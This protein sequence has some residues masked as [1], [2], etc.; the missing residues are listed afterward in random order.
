LTDMKVSPAK[1]EIEKLVLLIEEH[2]HRY[3]VLN[4]PVISDEEYDRLL[5]KLIDLEEE[6][7]KFKSA[8]SPTQRV[9]AKVQGDLPT[10][11]HRLPMLSLDNTYSLE[12]LKQ[13]YERVVK[14]LD[15]LQPALTAE[16]KIDGLSCALTY[17]HGQL[18]LA[19]TRGDGSTGEDVTHNA[20]TIRDIP[21]SLKGKVPNLLEVRGEVYMDKKD[22]N[23][24]NGQRKDNGEVLFANPRN[25]AAGSLKLLDARLTAQRRLKFFVH[26]PGLWE[27]KAPL[28]QWEFLEQV[29]RNGFVVNSYNRLCRNFDEVIVFCKE[30]A[31]KRE[32][33]SFDVDGIVVKVNDL[34]QQA[35]LGHTLKSPRWAVAFKFPAYQASTVIKE[36][37][38]QVGR[39]GVLTPVA[40]LEPVPCAGVVISRA[41]LHNFDEIK[42]LGVNSGDRVLLERAGD[43]I[44]KIVKVLEKNS[45]GEFVI[46]K[47]CP[48]CNAKIQ[49][50]KEGDV[51][52]RC[53]NPSCPKQLERLLVHFASRGAMD[54]EGLGES[55]VDQLLGHGLISDLADIY[56]LKKEQ[57]LALDL[58]ADKKAENLLKAITVSKSKPLSKFLY[59]LGIANIGIKAAVNL[60]GHCGSLDAIINIQAEQL[61]TIDEIGPVMAGSVVEY[62]KQP[63]VKKLLAKFKDGGLNFLEP[64]RQ[65]SGN[66][67]EGKKFV[68][69]GE[70]SGINREEAG[71]WVQ[72]Q[73]G[74]VLAS[75][76]KNLDYLVVGENPGSKLAQAKQLGVKILNQK[77][78]EAIFLK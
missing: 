43:V 3:Y 76:S 18:V 56:F 63:Q 14:G 54:I 8:A 34:K 15:G 23:K 75:V 44:P 12:E 41:T 7:P 2:N 9:G 62:F 48:S 33:I 60:A 32:E 50:E 68:F 27:G 25:A 35:Q 42:R 59:G 73:G 38:V 10:I 21:L 49:K 30:Y 37:V 28:T 22:F 51:A 47:L 16:L 45:K 53:L 46:P 13:W 77:E 65:A 11:K 70:L 17:R 19:A 52:Y 57:L 67:L 1:K 69:T 55:I 4:D 31:S 72:N 29:K 20:K 58:F 6:F 5:K 64:Q 40:E 61:Q 66:R 78:F 26:S 74:K 71:L 36:I 39:T 24:L